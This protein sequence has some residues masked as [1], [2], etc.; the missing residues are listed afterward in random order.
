MAWTSFCFSSSKAS[1]TDL[2][3]FDPLG[4][5]LCSPELFSS[6]KKV[7]FAGK[8]E[9]KVTTTITNSREPLLRPARPS[10]NFFL[11]TRVRQ[12]SVEEKENEKENNNKGN[13]KEKKEVTPS[14]PIFWHEKKKTSFLCFG[15]IFDEENFMFGKLKRKKK[16]KTWRHEHATERGCGWGCTRIMRA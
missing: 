3:L 15:L 14:S 5:F 8:G 7:S 6:K 9:K 11:Y 2:P 13:K 12:T 16:R 1:Q 10:E 4:R